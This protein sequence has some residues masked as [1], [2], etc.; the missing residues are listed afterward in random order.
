MTKTNTTRV[1]DEY[2][3]TRAGRAPLPLPDRA[4][5]IPVV[6]TMVRFNE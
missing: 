4:R 1:L 6:R 3:A 5:S 2:P